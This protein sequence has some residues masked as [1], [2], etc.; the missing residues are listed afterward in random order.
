MICC[1]G[2]QNK[3]DNEL[4]SLKAEK[5]K[6]EELLQ[7]YMDAKNFLQKLTPKDILDQR[8]R[9]INTKI[10]EFKQQWM[11]REQLNKDGIKP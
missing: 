1:T 9:K 11:E 4:T 3:L 5:T 2:Y 6:N 10:E 8:E 7:K